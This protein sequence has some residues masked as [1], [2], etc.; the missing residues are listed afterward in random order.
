MVEDYIFD[1]VMSGTRLSSVLV[2]ESND[3]ESEGDVDKCPCLD[4]IHFVN[5]LYANEMAR[6]QSL[7]SKEKQSV[8]VHGLCSSSSAVP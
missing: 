7:E 6:W 4:S 2:E 1:E 5:A 8:P 3:K